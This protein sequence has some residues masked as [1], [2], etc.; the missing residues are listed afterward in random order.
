MGEYKVPTDVEAEDKILGPLSL[1][2]A[3]YVIIGLAWG[4][5]MWRIFTDNYI[6]MAIS[7][8]PVTGFFLLLGFGRR[9]EQSFEHYFVAVVQYF[10]IPRMR[11]WDKD[12]QQEELVTSDKIAPVI[13]SHKNITHGSLE[14]LA[15]ALDTH[16]AQKD[17]TIQ[18]PDE[19]G[20]TANLSQRII[21]P[22]QLAPN[23]TKPTITHD[24]TLQDDVL[25]TTSE[26]SQEVNELLE[27]V[28]VDIHRQALHDITAQ[29]NDNN[30]TPT[31]PATSSQ[32]TIDNAIINKVMLQ[33]NNLSVAQIAKEAGE[34]IIPAGQS[35]NIT[36][37][38]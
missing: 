21:S 19:S 34:N 35:I 31:N 8:L 25:D 5:L 9:Q 37:T 29:L 36:A 27:N 6:P 14:Q 1:R 2:Q 10:T 38:S 33:S 18:L 24:A 20:Q 23:D 12:L 4:A 28:T 7:I 15:L 26:R 17:P 16:G 3:I 32:P 30:S 13:V 22:T 11:I